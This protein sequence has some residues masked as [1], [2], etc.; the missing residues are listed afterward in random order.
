MTDVNERVYTG[1]RVS[2]VDL[3][4]MR[5]DPEYQELTD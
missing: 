4:R 5:S 3:G 2:S 1:G